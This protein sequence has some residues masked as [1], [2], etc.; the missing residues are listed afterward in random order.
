MRTVSALAGAGMGAWVAA[1]WL[2]VREENARPQAEGAEQA[3]ELER[4]RADLAVLE[5]MVS[6]R[7][8]EP[9]AARAVCGRRGRG[10]GP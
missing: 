7:S 9:S 6:G 4:V 10:A 1:R 5:R 2:V 3:A 8:S